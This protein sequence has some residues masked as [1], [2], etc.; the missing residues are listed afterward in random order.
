[1]GTG[2]RSP[3]LGGATRDGDGGDGRHLKRF[4]AYLRPHRKR[5]LHIA[6]WVTLLALLRLPVPLA[7]K[8]LIDEIIPGGSRSALH[9]LGVVLLAYYVFNQV[10]HVIKG[11]LLVGLKEK[12]TYRL[13]LDLLGR[14][15]DQSTSFHE[16]H[17]SGYLSS[18]VL[19]ET[20]KAEGLISQGA[21]ELLLDVLTFVF[22][23]GVMAFFHLKLTLLCVALLPFYF[24]TVAVFGRRVKEASVGIQESTGKVLG[25]LQQTLAGLSVVK[26]FGRERREL[27]KHS[28][29]SRGAIRDRIRLTGL[30]FLSTGSTALIGA[31]GPL[32]V[33]WYGGSQVMAGELTLGAMVAFLSY[34]SYLFGP[35]KKVADLGLRVKEAMGALGRVF[36]VMDRPPEVREPANP[37]TLARVEGV[38]RFE[39]VHF[40][41]D[42][43]SEVLRGIDLAA[44][45]GEIVALVGASGAGKSTLMSLLLRL[46]DPDRGRITID[47]VD[48]RH[49]DRRSRLAAVAPVFQDPFLFAG[50]VYDN[51]RYGAPG[52][53]APEVQ[54]AAEAANADEF[55]RRLPGG[56][57]C[58]VGE[59]GAGLSGGQ[60]QRIAIARALVKKAPILILD[61]ATAFLD[62]RSERMI[63]EAL[64][65]LRHRHTVFLIAHRLGTLRL[66][67]R[68][69]LLQEGRI[70][71]EGGPELLAQG[72]G[73]VLRLFRGD[74]RETA[75]LRRGP[76]GAPA[77]GPP[78]RAAVGGG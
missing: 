59:R 32:V 47:G 4:L 28:R 31:L 30:L 65:R 14:L 10:V 43:R 76:G 13:Q 46:H 20:R 67:D 38:V 69:I 41:Y 72:D 78:L 16:R 50:T 7:T 42:G 51:I 11:F 6:F 25:N 62:S 68:V 58:P 49:L 29:L 77:D 66:A 19:N 33:I 55:I 61:E 22:G 2:V 34:L 35:T 8:Y 36:E 26:A 57:H 37:L 23:L 44:R 18:R 27:I 15:L 45:P 52:V 70:A 64:D 17:Q 21:F 73:P 74:G 12:V 54:A 53:D 60:K 39:G 63:Q 24:V 9:L 40:S 3:G 75:P 71:V 56:L 1:M 5:I 48:L